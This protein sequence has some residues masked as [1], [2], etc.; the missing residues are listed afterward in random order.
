MPPECEL[1]GSKDAKRKTKID[2]AILSVCDNCVSFGEE[3][4]VI[5]FKSVKKEIPKI[6]E[7]EKVIK[8]N[9]HIIIKNSREKMNLTQKQLAKKLSE[10]ASS[11]KRIEEGWEPHLGLI[12]KLEKFFNIQ[13]IEEMEEKTLG[14]RIERKKLT[15]GDVVEVH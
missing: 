3:I 2:E 10:K 13:L 15:I 9:F 11:I 14:K 7:L 8:N 4:P 6:Q 12:N 1:C 5:E